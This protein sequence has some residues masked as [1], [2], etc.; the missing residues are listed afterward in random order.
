MAKIASRLTKSE[1]EILETM[2]EYGK[3]ITAT[4][5]TKTAINKTWKSSSIHILINSLLDKKLIEVAGFEKTTKN[6]ARKF[7][8][9][10]PRNEFM[11]QEMLFNFNNSAEVLFDALIKMSSKEDLILAKAKIEKRLS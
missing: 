10:L 7:Q 6:Y 2:W 1:L 8:P 4:N 3:P 5:I 9:V 11:L